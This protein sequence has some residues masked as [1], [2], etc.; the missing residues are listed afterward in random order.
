MAPYLTVLMEG[1]AEQTI[2]RSRFI[3][4]AAPAR[5]VLECECFFDRIRREHR[6]ATHNVPA[7]ALGE[8]GRLQWAGD[9]GEPRGTSG[10][11]IVHMLVQEGISDVAVMVARYFGGVKLGKGGLVRAYTGTAK[12]ALAD[13]GLGKV[14]ELLMLGVKVSYTGYNR[15]EA[16]AGGAFTINNAVFA[17]EVTVSLICEP[18]LKDIVVKQTLAVCQSASFVTERLERVVTALTERRHNDK[19]VG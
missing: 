17:E 14:S 18:E 8:G 11:P 9:D 6:Q 7:Y 5:T 19:I 4:Y 10:A 1:R 12:L 2:E 3:G 15:L 16:A 13:A